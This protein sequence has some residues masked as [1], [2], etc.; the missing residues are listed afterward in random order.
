[1]P[2][3]AEMAQDPEEFERL[4]AEMVGGSETDWERLD[5]VRGIYNRAVIFDAPRFHARD[6]KHGFGDGAED[7]RMV[8][9]C[10]FVTD[11]K[12]G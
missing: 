6:P 3:F 2:S 7:G 1:M 5:F 9:V 11:L 8:W 10:H 12:V 4:K